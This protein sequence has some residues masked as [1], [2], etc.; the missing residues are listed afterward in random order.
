MELHLIETLLR[1]KATCESSIKPP[2][3]NKPLPLSIKLPPPLPYLF[4]TNK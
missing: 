4:F 1:N 3:S 2:L